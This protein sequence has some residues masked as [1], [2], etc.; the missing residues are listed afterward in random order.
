MTDGTRPWIGE[1]RV[2]GGLEQQ[3]RILGVGLSVV[4]SVYPRLRRRDYEDPSMQGTHDEGG[5]GC[6]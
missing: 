2:A 1:R 3:V 6:G 4:E 5:R